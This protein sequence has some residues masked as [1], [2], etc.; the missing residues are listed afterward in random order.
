MSDYIYR[1]QSRLR[2]D[3]LQALVQVQQAA[4]RA[5]IHVFLAGG[6]VRDLMSGVPIGDLD[7]AVE[8]P[9][10]K[11]VRQ[12]DQ[13]LF[14]VTG[15]D[16]DR[17]LA[18]M[19]FG[20]ATV[21]I[22]MCRREHHAKAGARPQISPAGI[23]DD[24]R[25]RDFSVNAVALSLN[26][27][28]RGLLLDPTNG[29]ADIERKE[30]RAI[31]NYSFHDD[32]SRLLRLVRLKARLKYAVEDRTRV[33]FDAALEAGV[34]EHI[35]PRALLQELRQLATEPDGADAVK[36]L[37][38]AGLVRLFE[39]HLGKKLD[40]PALSKLD[41]CRRV[42]ESA[43]TGVD[44]FGPFLYCLT[45]KLSAA[46]R[47]G[48][49]TRTGM[50]PSEAN[51]W[52]GLE[53]HAKAVQKLLT[54]KQTALHSRLYRTLLAE[55]PAVALFLLGFS[56]LQPVRDRIKTYFT[57]LRPLAGS[58]TDQEVEQTGVK[59]DSGK[60]AAARDAFVAARLD[61]KTPGKA[62]AAKAPAG[63]A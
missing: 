50:K 19:R 58:I 11:L 54:G 51:A 13:R 4:E 47:A 15:T 37:A 23:Q 9:A 10:L 8:A 31:S 20:G 42:V 2:P 56:P 61:R 32:P 43:A 57:Q 14:T 60:F 12:L 27:A 63:H 29:L 1:L 48:L 49:R 62:E 34:E 38:A 25:R 39:P 24:L 7:F 35:S 55:D 21:E 18:E 53:A 33:Q 3:Q 5:H 6:A 59:R 52:T 36:A 46:E 44:A 17:Q 41:K 28:S 26:P 30:L 45:R 16:E 22:A 40:L